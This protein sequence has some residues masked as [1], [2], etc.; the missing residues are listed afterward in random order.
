MWCSVSA[1]KYQCVSMYS[2]LHTHTTRVV[3]P[4]NFHGAGV[5]R[6]HLWMFVVLDTVAVLSVWVCMYVGV[7][8]CVSWGQNTFMGPK[9]IAST[10]ECLL[11]LKLLLYYLCGCVCMWV[12][13]RVCVSW[14]QNIFMGTELIASTCECL[15]L[16]KL[17]LYYLCGCGCVCVCVCVCRETRTLPRDGVDGDHLWMFFVGVIVAVVCVYVC[18]CREA[19]TLPWGR[20]WWRAL[21]N[22]CCWCYCCCNICVGV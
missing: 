10:C 22:I 3:R 11:F 14:G 19:R 18:V 5:H 21:L 7:C 8:V 6:E 16:V 2:K 15:L 9:L 4:E 17:L 20:S 12:C 13:V 1:Y